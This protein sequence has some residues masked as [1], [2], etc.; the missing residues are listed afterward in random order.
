LLLTALLTADCFAAADCCCDTVPTIGKGI[1][2]F[3]G[4]TLPLSVPSSFST[5]A[6]GGCFTQCPAG[7]KTRGTMGG[8][9]NYSCK[10]IAKK[11][12]FLCSLN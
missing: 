12:E 1:M 4:F 11:F 10:R 7:G 8:I 2:M 6:T 5:A 9:S 3:A